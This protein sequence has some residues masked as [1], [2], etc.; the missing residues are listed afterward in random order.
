MSS[1]KVVDA[2]IVRVQ[3]FLRFDSTGE[4]L[5]RL[6]PFDIGNHRIYTVVHQ[7]RRFVYF[8]ERGGPEPI[9]SDTDPAFVGFTYLGSFAS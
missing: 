3:K 7:G 6:N 1:E 5:S 9:T 2:T 8:L 4:T